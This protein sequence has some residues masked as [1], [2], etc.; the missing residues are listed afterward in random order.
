MSIKE[1]VGYWYND[2]RGTLGFLLGVATMLLLMSRSVNRVMPISS[3]KVQKSGVLQ[4]ITTA[5][6][7]KDTLL[8]IPLRAFFHT[9]ID[10]MI[11]K[12][13]IK[14]QPAEKQNSIFSA[15]KYDTVGKSM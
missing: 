13:M 3:K 5:N 7:Q 1:R 14:V 2:N 6:G 12:D 15:I 10:C 11:A 8:V 9:A 4:E